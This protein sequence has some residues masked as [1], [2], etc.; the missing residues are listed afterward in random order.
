MT[1]RYIILYLIM[2]LCSNLF[3]TE[4]ELNEV[5]EII[6]NTH[7]E[8]EMGQIKNLQIA[9]FNENLISFEVYGDD[10]TIK[11]FLYNT[12]EKSIYQIQSVNYLTSKSSKR[13]YYLKNR[14]V[15]WHPTENWFVFYGNGHHNRDQLFICKVLV[16][17]LINDFSIKGWMIDVREKR[18]T[19]GYYQQPCFD[20]NGKNLFFSRKIRLKD[21]KARYNRT[22]NIAYIENLTDLESSKFE[23][24]EFEVAVEKKFHQ[25]SPICS[26]TN[27][28]LVAY[29][30]YRNMKKRG[31][32]FY[33]DYSINI[34]NIKTEEIAVVDKM[35]GYEDYPFQWSPSGNYIFYFKALSLLM[36]KQNFIDDQMNI[37]NL[38]YAKVI[39][40]DGNLKI[41]IQ[42]N[43][44]SDILLEDVTGKNHG[45]AFINEDN[46]LVSKFDPMEAI[47]LVDIQKWKDLDKNY[48]TK[49]DFSN[50]TDYPI[51]IGSNLYFVSY[52]LVQNNTRITVDLSEVKITLPEGQSRVLTSASAIEDQIEQYK[53][54]IAEHQKNLE[55]IEKELSELLN[56]L[57]DENKQFSDLAK[58]KETLAASKD[59]ELATLNNFRDKKSSGLETEQQ[60]S[61]LITQK[62]EI[63]VK[64]KNNLDTVDI[65]NSKI[66]KLLQ[67]K[68]TLHE[69]KSNTLE[70]VVQYK[71]KLAEEL[72]TETETTAIKNKINKAKLDLAEIENSLSK[73]NTEIE[74]EKNIR[75]KLKS[76]LVVKNTEKTK[77]LGSIDNLKIEKAK[78]L[79]SEGMLVSFETQL[80]ELNTKSKNIST[81]IETLETELNAE[82]SNLAS[83]TDIQSAMK[84]EKSGLLSS[85]DKLENDKIASLSKNKNEKLTTL[86]TSLDKLKLDLEIIT[87]KLD[88]F[89][90][91]LAEKNKNLESDRKLLK[92]K[93]DEK[94][95]SI[96][97]IENLTTAKTQ[98]N[99][100]DD[101]A[102][103]KKEDEEALAKKK[104]EEEQAKKDKE[105]AD[106]AAKIKKE[107]EELAD[108]EKAA[109]EQAKKDKEA[110]DLAAKKKK[111]AE[112]LANKENEKKD[113]Y[114]DE[115]EYADEEEYFDEDEY[116]Y[117]DEEYFDEEEDYFDNNTTT[118][119]GKTG[120][121]RRRR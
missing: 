1:K 81:E 25:I 96:K 82:K 38:K 93:T 61:Q 119:T 2:I 73:L 22:Y 77:A 101:L 53:I 56:D 100:D 20:S 54:Q 5:T 64:I 42:S 104:A 57:D 59:T 40:D 21:K 89:T 19:A 24:V 7:K 106:L 103:Q 46:I 115:D 99:K 117:S 30:S 47:T 76:D 98:A 60:I 116:E 35:D 86:Q 91:I 68:S 79:E 121:T 55:P 34:V 29:T 41:F 112:E 94:L 65:E 66:R 87:E 17:Q 23:E 15:T 92:E 33:P 31:G 50:D 49:L 27:P 108:K 13:R 95:V 45:I 11:L 51:L 8:I 43:P 37:L 52:E 78:T 18:N 74:E 71:T 120:S 16:P 14:G 88:T 44:K 70:L 3:S 72:L 26:P 75:T 36:T 107:A 6:A 48:S 28:N 109:E 114:S 97:D 85:I 10:K 69:D 67:N 113:E 90:A 102:K 39:E 12:E 9:P 110:A 118:P 80:G 62:T 63:E 111:E 4:I 32:E 84:K 105:A 58:Q 83:N